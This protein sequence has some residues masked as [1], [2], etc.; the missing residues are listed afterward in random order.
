M[1][2]KAPRNASRTAPAVRAQGRGRGPFYALIAVI[3]IAGAFVLYRSANQPREDTF[4]VDRATL[5]RLGS[6]AP[7]GYIIGDTTAPVH[8]VEFA[9]FECHACMN[10]ATVT[11]PDV[12]QRLVE[13][14]QVSFEYYFFPLEQ[15][16]NAG[17]AAH[18][19]AC[20]AD[21]GRFWEMH[22]A[23]FSGFNDWALGAA[24]NPKGV[25]QRYAG[26]IGLDVGEWEACYDEG[27]HRDRILAHK[28]Y[29]LQLGVSSTPTFMIGDRMIPGA[30]NY[31]QFKGIVDSVS[32]MATSSAP[33]AEAD[34]RP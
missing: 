26:S 6:E 17:N 5:A 27:R 7:G 16:Q 1:S 28:S 9:D 23:I 30:L 11:E 13:T 15:H 20:A 4:Q 22:D 2:R 31:D 21:Q 24:R 18:A 19:A 32:A 25:F 34:A 12:R 10:F 29:A 33:I 3:V 14:G 8:V